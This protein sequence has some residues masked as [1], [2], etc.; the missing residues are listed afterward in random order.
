MIIYHLYFTGSKNSVNL[1]ACYTLKSIYDKNNTDRF[2][3]YKKNAT[4]WF[5]T[6]FKMLF[7][8]SFEKQQ[9]FCGPELTGDLGPGFW[10]WCGKVVWR[11]QYRDHAQHAKVKDRY[12]CRKH[13][14]SKTSEVYVLVKLSGKR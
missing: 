4:R 6:I 8:V 3:I 5:T 1:R 13:C 14:R 12:D 2:E 10:L 9:L 11:V 7:F